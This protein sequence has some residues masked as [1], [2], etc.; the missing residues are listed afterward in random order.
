MR[1]KNRDESGVGTI[2]I[3]ICMVLL[4]GA[5]GIAIDVSRAV[6]VT[7]SAQNSAD[8]VA[9]AMGR[10]CVEHGSLSPTAA[11]DAFIRTGPAIG[12]GQSQTL[13]AGGCAAGFVK[14]RATETMDYTFSK[15]FTALVGA[16]DTT[17]RSRPAT[18]RW[19]EMTAGFIFPF[20]FSNCAFPDTFV[21]GHDTTPGTLMMLYGQKVRT[22]CPRD[23]D[24][25]AGQVDNSKGFVPGGCQLT[26]V[27]NTLTDSTGNNFIGT[28]CDNTDINT[29]VGKDVLLPVWGSASGSPSDYKITSL[30]GFHVLGWSGNGNSAADRG[31]AMKKRCTASDPDGF[32]G[33]PVTKGDDSKPCLFG[34][35][36]SFTSTTGGSNGGKCFLNPLS[37]ACLVYLDS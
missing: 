5:V 21:S 37:S 10:D 26:S 20:T 35:V 24:G 12:D 3:V 4:L 34:Y 32:M 11:Y 14:A 31:G 2:V 29:Y 33:D 19:G 15:V 18:V 13:E 16:P 23:S 22:T 28:N 1:L 7:R 30:V 9:L 8:A 17:T 36:T 6:A 27:G 25:T